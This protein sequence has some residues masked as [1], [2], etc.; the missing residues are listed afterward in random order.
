MQIA[1]KEYFPLRD[2]M[3]F[4]NEI[5]WGSN[6]GVAGYYFLE[7]IADKIDCDTVY[8]KKR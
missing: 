3:Y 5:G 7:G 6:I 2:W 4:R 1:G 8:K